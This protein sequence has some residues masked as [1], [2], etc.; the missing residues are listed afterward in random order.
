VSRD[1]LLQVFFKKHFLQA[2]EI[3]SRVIMD[4]FKIRGDIHDS[5]C[6][7][8][9][10]DGKFATSTAGLIDINETGGKFATGIKDTGGK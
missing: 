6:T 7:T 10:N 9:I 1:I 4:F 5:K 2:P 8:G 3:N